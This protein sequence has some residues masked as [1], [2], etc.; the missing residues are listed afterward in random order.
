MEWM[1]RLSR[2]LT[3]PR[4]AVVLSVSPKPG[5][6][7]GLCNNVKRLPRA[8]AAKDYAP[9][10]SGN[11]RP[12]PRADMTCRW[13]TTC[14]TGLQRQLQEPE[15]GRRYN[16]S[17]DRRV[18][19]VTGGGAGSLFPPSHRLGN[20]RAHDGAAGPRCLVDGVVPAQAAARCHRAERPQKR[21]R[22]VNCAFR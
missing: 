14:C 19:A 18:L 16:L 13:T 5:Q 22:R 3:Q 10:P 4:D 7:G 6:T 11:S 17:L 21:S 2:H 9:K 15:V 20:V 12:P 1:V 8:C